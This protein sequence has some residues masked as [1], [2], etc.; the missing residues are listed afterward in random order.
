MK[1]QFVDIPAIKKPIARAE[2]FEKKALATYKLDVMGLCAFGCLYCSSPTGNYLRI[3]QGPFAEFGVEQLGER[4]LPAE[5]PELCY[6][7]PEI[8]ERMEN[9]LAHKRPGFGAGQTLV[10]SMLTDAFSPWAI[11]SG[12]TR[13]ALDLVLDRTAFRVRVL[14][15][16]AVVGQEPWLSYFQEHRDRVVVG[17]SVGTLDADW[18][19]RIEL[20]TSSPAARIQA[21]HNL[22]DAGVPTFGMLCPIFP[23]VLEGDGIE[24]LAQAIRPD[25]AE[26][27]WAEPYN[28]RNNWESVRDG[29][30]VGSPGYRWFGEVYG[31]KRK[32]AWSRYTTDLYVRLKAAAEAGGW[33]HKLRYLLYE[34]NITAEDAPAFKGLHGVLLQ[35]KSD[36]AGRSKNPAMA[37]LEPMKGGR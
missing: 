34:D 19:R 4:L 5:M 14:T 6:R 35:C 17:L 25:L 28:D 16:N 22:Q 13:K 20:G 3:N 23:D 26:H 11:A 8:L 1:N 37:A 32:A 2:G 31:E 10:Y 29:Y 18:S 30:P 24:R 27:V 9:Q 15:K 33:M 12:M 7:W 36:E 21:T